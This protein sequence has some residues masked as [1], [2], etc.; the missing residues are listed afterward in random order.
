MVKGY[1]KTLEASLSIVLVLVFIVFL[2]PQ[3]SYIEPQASDK[4]H[5]CLEHLEQGGLLGYYAEN[6][7]ESELN[8]DM[9]SCMLPFNATARICSSADCSASLPS[10]KSVFMSSYMTAGQA[11]F[12]PRLINVWVWSK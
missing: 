9:I 1:M 12:G 8:R 5:Y 7:M 4:T 11:V 3:R 10:G 2:F 6:G